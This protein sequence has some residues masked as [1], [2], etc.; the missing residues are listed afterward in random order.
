M[1]NL[2]GFYAY[3]I[4]TVHSTPINLYEP[5]VVHM[6]RT[7]DLIALYGRHEICNGSRYVLM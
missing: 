6:F 4:H 7:S 1:V 5:I 3:F 2:W